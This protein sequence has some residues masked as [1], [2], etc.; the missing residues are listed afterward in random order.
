MAKT[1]TLDGVKTV[2]SKTGLVDNVMKDVPTKTQS[3]V[4]FVSRILVK[5][6]ITSD[7]VTEILRFGVKMRVRLDKKSVRAKDKPVDI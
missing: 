2:L 1:E 3:L 7:I 6:W 4:M 5:V